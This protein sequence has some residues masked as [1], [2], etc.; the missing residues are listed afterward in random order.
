MYNKY[1]LKQINLGIESGVDVSKYTGPK[2]TWLQMYEIRV[3][4]EGKDDVQ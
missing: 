4:L 2:Y 1:Q 3:R